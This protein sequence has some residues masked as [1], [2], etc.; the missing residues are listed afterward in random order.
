MIRDLLFMGIFMFGL[1]FFVIGMYHA[2]SA[3]NEAF[4]SNDAITPTAKTMFNAQATRY[5]EW[6][7]YTY[8]TIMIAIFIGILVLS[9][10]LSTEPIFFW[11]IWL[12]VMVFGIVAGYMANIWIE[13]TS[14]GTLAIA[15]SQF[16]I[17]NYTLSNY[18]GVMLILGMMMAIVFFAKPS[19][20]GA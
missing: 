19:G 14:T 15:V 5:P 11:A 13:T 16:P 20:L 12:F 9:Y 2:W 8:L 7:D 4:Q 18:M 10:F 17:M 3:T 6:M 1:A